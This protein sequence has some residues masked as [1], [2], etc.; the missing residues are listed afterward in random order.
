M[1]FSYTKYII[2]FVYKNIL[3][4]QP[5]KYLQSQS[6]CSYIL[7]YKDKIG[8]L[9]LLTFFPTR[10]VYFYSRKQLRVRRF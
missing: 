2:Y 1:N 8:S 7:V 5:L 9:N 4:F 3:F 10:K 6:I